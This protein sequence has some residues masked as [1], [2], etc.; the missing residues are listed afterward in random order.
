MTVIE[1]FSDFCV[2]VDRY[3]HED[4][5]GSW[6]VGQGAF[7][8]LCR[9]RPDLAELV[10]GSDFDPFYQDRNLAAFY[11]YLARHWNDGEN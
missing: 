2:A 7:N 4:M 11:S 5:P 6:R 8:L 10:R 1:T 3:T 9:L